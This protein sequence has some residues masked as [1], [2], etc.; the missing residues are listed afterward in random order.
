L[1]IF[2]DPKLAAGRYKTGGRKSMSVV[3]RTG[4]ERGCEA[5]AAIADGNRNKKQ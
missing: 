4:D 5:S 3:K 1:T 2:E